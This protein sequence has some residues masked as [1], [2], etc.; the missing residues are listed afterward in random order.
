MQRDKGHILLDLEEI[1][2]VSPSPEPGCRIVTKQNQIYYV[3]LEV[4]EVE[5]LIAASKG[6]KKGDL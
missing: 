4:Y 3:D 5:D 6:N 1:S 2:S